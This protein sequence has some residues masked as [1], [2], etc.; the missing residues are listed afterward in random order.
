MEP[1]MVVDTHPQIPEQVEEARALLGLIPRLLEDNAAL[2]AQVEA[3]EKEVSEL[4]GELEPLRAEV[5]RCRADRDELTE[6]FGRVMSEVSTLL[7]ELAPRFR[8][9]QRPSPFAREA[10]ANGTTGA[11]VPRGLA[12]KLTVLR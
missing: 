10:H 7:G 1:M 12:A 5:Q 8:L 6:A 4:R 2:R 9:P 11:D 3:A